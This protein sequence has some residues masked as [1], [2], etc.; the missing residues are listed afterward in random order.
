M[1]SSMTMSGAETALGS[2]G[3]GGMAAIFLT[4][5]I[6]GIK[7]KGKKRLAAVPA[8]V[9]GIFAG[10][11]FDRAG[12]PWNTISQSLRDMVTEVSSTG[13]LGAMGP[14]FAA[15]FLLA[16]FFYLKLSPAIGAILGLLM[17]SAWAAAPD[18]LWRVPLK[19]VGTILGIVGG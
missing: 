15:L 6:L 5:L 14:G 7:G 16:L 18:S 17:A 8:V 3:A 19:L 12:D 11:E 1:N 9:V 4:V 2:V 10:V 13:E